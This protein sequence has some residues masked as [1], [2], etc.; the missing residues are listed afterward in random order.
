MV[1]PDK[2][3]R[4]NPEFQNALHLIEHTNSSVYLTGRAG[5]GKSTFL[6][7]ICEVTHKKHIVLAP[8]GIAAINAGGVTIHS[9]FKIPFRPI[10]PNDPD[11]STSKRRIYDFL[12][13]N[14]S[15]IK[16][17]KEV[18]LI[19]IDEISMVRG[20]ILDF[21]DQV[22]RV[23]TGNKNRP[24]GGKQMLMVGDAFQLQ[25]VVKRNEWQILNR[26][27][28]T[29]YFFSANVFTQI[30]L[31]QIELKKVYRQKAS[32]FVNILD[33][34]RLKQEPDKQIQLI[35]KRVKPNYKTPTDEL[36]IT[37]ATRRDT[38]NYI[39]EQKLTELEGKEVSFDGEITGEFPQSNLPTLKS[40]ILKEN[41]Q[42][43]FVK[44][45]I[46]KRWY[47]GTLGIVEE[48]SD[49]G[50]Y[51][52]LENDQI[53]LVAREK[54]ENLRYKFDEKNNQIIAEELGSFTQYPLKLAWAVT[55]HKSQGLTFDKVVIDFSGG[56]FA[57]GQL[58]VALSR[59]RSLDGMILK[60]PVTRND[61]IVNREVVEFSKK[62]NNKELIQKQ[63]NNAKADNAYNEA[64]NSIRDQEW[65]KAVENLA[66][67]TQLRNDLHRP[68][69]Q[70]LAAKEMRFVKHYK[71]EIVRL[72]AEVEKMRKNTKEF[73]QEYYLMA[74]ECE[75]KFND[76]R[77]AIANLNKAVKLNPLFTDALMRRA[78]LLMETGDTKAAEKDCTSILKTNQRH[79]NALLLRGEIRIINNNINKAYK[80]LLEARGIKK[81]NPKV[82]YLLSKVFTKMG[83]TEKA[84]DFKNIGRSLEN[85]EK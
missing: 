20:D 52:R 55:V 85:P 23:Y 28:K 79:F 82:Y 18:E 64:L 61:I 44:N 32:E 38:V 31:V 41:A 84:Q 80:D 34:I 40:L 4:K 48:I 60:T 9:F 53:Y 5:T 37:L 63:L 42:V 58:Y 26:F 67:A 43:M 11:L 71:N 2:I 17:I 70:R 10:M 1:S 69:I 19:I 81:A 46:E 15:K 29:P 75:T 27:Y 6:R 49:K 78:Q 8:T 3:D 7:Y 66:I 36:F 59:C 62:A 54:W 14:R 24:F 22:L 50:I 39:N 13:Y 30:P 45:D 12:K 56:A 25:P 21:I 57:G 76:T 47:N 72:E 77:S 83:E 35:N 33:S 51:V 74:N 65:K 68:A 73:A 16:L